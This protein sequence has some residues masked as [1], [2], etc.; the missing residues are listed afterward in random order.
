M[1]VLDLKITKV[2][3]SRL[4]Q[5]DQNNIQFAKIYC[6]HMLV[7]DYKDGTW[8]QPEI[9]PYGDL[10]MSPATT[11]IHYG[12]A[13]FEGIKAYKSKDGQV[14]I[15]R[16]LDNFKRFNISAHRMAM[17][18]VPEEIFLQG[19]KE[20]ISMDQD[21]VPTAEGSS[22]YIRPF[23]FATD[24]FIGVRPPTK[25]RFMI[26]NS[27]A[28]AYYNKPIRIYVQ[29]KYVRAFPGGVGYA[30]AAG[31]YA[32]AMYPT[33]EIQ[34]KGYDQ[35]L[36]LD[37]IEQ[38]YIQEIGTMNVFFVV[39]DRVLTPSL[40]EGTILDGI[41]RKSVIELLN[42]R[43]ITVEERRIS[44][45]EIL[46]FYD[47]GELLE[48]FGAGTAAV[49]APIAELH[50]KG[51]DMVLPPQDTWLVSSSI[52]QELADIRYG[53]AEDKHNWMYPVN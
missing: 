14:R 24:E 23:M 2:D 36:W 34:S 52:K 40:D 30:K 32:A 6:D 46:E 21:W 31:N 18:E 16:P 47:K 33:V 4:D 11:F 35:N 3:R 9:M 25:F 49:I 48:V 20:L 13:I 29:D 44:I 38:K 17:A 53:V 7:A 51:K 43:N 26:I 27:P 37:G 28:G 12:Q 19:M 22:L 1:N 50:Y 15:F 10:T 45:D 41:T 42:D 39:G 5:L 8:G